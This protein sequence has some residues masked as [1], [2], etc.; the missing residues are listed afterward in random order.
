MGRY[1]PD[2]APQL[3]PR[4]PDVAPTDPS[5]SWSGGPSRRQDDRPRVS[6]HRDQG[7]SPTHAQWNDMARRRNPRDH[8]PRDLDRG[9]R[10][11]QL[12]PDVTWPGRD[13]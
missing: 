7:Y 4:R 6:D 9:Q 13:G 1:R 2:N 8:R 5:A 10:H 12:G 3:N 11:H